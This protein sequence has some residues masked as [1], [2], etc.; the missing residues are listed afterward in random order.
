MLGFAGFGSRVWQDDAVGI[1]SVEVFLRAQE[2]EVGIYEA[3]V[4]EKGAVGV[5][6]ARFE[7]AFGEVGSCAVV[8]GLPVFS[9]AAFG[10]VAVAAAPGVGCAGGGT[11][12]PVFPFFC[13]VHEARAKAVQAFGTYEVGAAAGC[14]FV[15][16]GF[17]VAAHCGDC[18]REG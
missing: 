18:S 3:G 16:R 7:K 17:E 13:I 12:I 9:G 14:G 8:V 4:E 11:H 2:G 1:V 5:L 6:R 10:D 15:A